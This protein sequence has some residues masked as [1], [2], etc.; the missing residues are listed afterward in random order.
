MIESNF[1]RTTYLIPDEP[2][3]DQM[4]SVLRGEIAA[5]ETYQSVLETMVDDPAAVELY[6]TLEDHRNAVSFWK[7]QI[8]REGL[9]PDNSSGPW[10][11][12][13]LAVVAAAKLLGN[14]AALRALREGEEHGLTL[15]LE[16]LTND[17]LTM[18][19]RNYIRDVL[20]PQQRGHI[21]ALEE[22]KKVH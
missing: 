3:V 7:E 8:Q 11:T 13:A 4:H 10:G 2:G 12:A 15:Y 21:T 16:L 1:D 5:V 17:E 20:I 19:Q 14:V 22:M 6:K 9:E 18:D